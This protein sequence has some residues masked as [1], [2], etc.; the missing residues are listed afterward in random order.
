MQ[1]FSPINHLLLALEENIKMEKCNLQANTILGNT[2]ACIHIRIKISE[3]EIL[4]L[5]L[6]GDLP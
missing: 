1:N 4:L 2:M 5:K 3:L 6:S